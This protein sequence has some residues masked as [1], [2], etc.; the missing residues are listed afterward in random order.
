M[1]RSV[2]VRLRA[3]VSQFKAA[4]AESASATTAVGSAAIAAGGKATAAEVA[5]AKAAAEAARSARL[6]ETAM[7]RAV[8]SAEKNKQAWTT[9]GTIIAGAGNSG[10][11]SPCVR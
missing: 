2:L 6:S 4:M 8:L 10:P 5:K 11:A 1:E 3:E 7:G 9:T